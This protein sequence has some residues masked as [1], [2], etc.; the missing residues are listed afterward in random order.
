MKT[1]IHAIAGGIAFLTILTFWT[2]TVLSELFGS[3][4]TIAFVKAMILRGM[5][6]LIPAMIIVGGSGMALGGKRTDTL[7]S[8]KKKRMPFIAA[9][10]LL[11]LLP[12]AFILADKAASGTF[13]I[14]FYGLQAIELLA[15]GTNLTLMGLNIRDGLRMTG[16]TGK[17][18]KVKLV[19]RDLINNGTMVLRFTKPAGFN[20]EAGQWARLTLIKPSNTDHGGSD[21]ILTIASA[22]EEAELTFA[23]RL[24]SSA[25]KQALAE[26]PIGSEVQLAA[27]QGTMTLPQD[28]KRPV[29]FIAGGI[30]ITPF[31]SMVRHASRFHGDQKITLFYSNRTEQDAVFLDELHQLEKANPNFNLVATL[32]NEANTDWQGETGHIDIDM[33]SRHLDDIRAPLYYLVGSPAMVFAMRSLLTKQGVSNQDIRTEEFS[34]Y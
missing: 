1:R 12:M 25:F 8:S 30:G 23:T 32:S 29:V 9:N 11:I 5:F 3:Y 13:D 20:H 16:K 26:L 4:E 24:R 17:S 27:P 33:L 31:L 19:S 21:R 14:W 10:G 6:I 28:S 22:P 34:G 15:G 2:S 7:A 18:N